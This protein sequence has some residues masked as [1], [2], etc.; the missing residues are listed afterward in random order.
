MQLLALG[1]MKFM[2]ECDRQKFNQVW[3]SNG[4]SWGDRT[5]F[6]GHCLDKANRTSSSSDCTGEVVS[7]KNRAGVVVDA[8]MPNIAFGYRCRE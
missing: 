1:R 2:I 5:G 8:G 3:K 6:V 4:L 7:I